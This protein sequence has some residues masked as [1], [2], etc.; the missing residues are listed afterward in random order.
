MAAKK[1]TH[2]VLVRVKARD[3]MSATE[4]R[5]E[6][7]TLI[8]DQCNYSAEP[9]DLRASKVSHVPKSWLSWITRDRV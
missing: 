1:K 4:V 8:N 7:R 9:D 6:V 5:R 2:Y 3:D